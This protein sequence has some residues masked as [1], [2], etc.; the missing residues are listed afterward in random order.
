M[1]IDLDKE[2]HVYT[3]DGI[4]KPSVSRIF[5]CVGVRKDSESPWRSIGGGEFC[6]DEVA[7]NFGDALHAIAVM[8]LRRKRFSYDPQMEAWVNGLRKFF[9]DNPDLVYPGEL[10]ETSLYSKLY[11]YAGTPDWV[12]SGSKNSIHIIDWKSSTASFVKK[13]RMQ[14]A[15]YGQLVKEHFG[16]TKMIHRRT[17]RIYENGYEED[18]RF[19]HPEDWANFVSLHNTFKFAA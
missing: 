5:D 4:E 6:S 11:G 14:T 8:M 19:N 15:A 13:W 3:L 17:V 1:I 9:A 16:I 7:S 10:I 18:R 2:S 12:T